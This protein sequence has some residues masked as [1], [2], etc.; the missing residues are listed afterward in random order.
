MNGATQVEHTK[1]LFR[2]RDRGDKCSEIISGGTR[3]RMHG[4]NR[5]DEIVSI[6]K[7]KA[8]LRNRNKAKRGITQKSQRELRDSSSLLVKNPKSI[9][10]S[11]LANESFEDDT[12]ELDDDQITMDEEY[13]FEEESV[14]VS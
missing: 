6:N 1:K 5:G 9:P 3:N 14:M 11:G 7:G 8:S 10:Y 12:F 13:D 2:F 4:I